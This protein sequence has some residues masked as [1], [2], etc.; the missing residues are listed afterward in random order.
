MNRKFRLLLILTLFYGVKLVGQKLDCQKIYIW[1]FK[2]DE[3][4][5]NDITKTITNEVEEIF[6]QINSCKILQRRKNA[7]LEKQKQNEIEVLNVEGM[8][9][10]LKSQLRTIEAEKV[11][12]GEV[13][14][15]FSF[16]CIVRISLESLSTKEI[17]KALKINIKAKEMIDPKDRYSILESEIR[18]FLDI[19]E[20]G[21]N[22]IDKNI[23][24]RI[25]TDDCNDLRSKASQMGF[26]LSSNCSY[27]VVE[28]EKDNGYYLIRVHSRGKLWD[29]YFSAYY[30]IINKSN[31]SL[32]KISR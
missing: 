17:L 8:S 29:E 13:E 6:S 10:G 19:K 9:S 1:D 23:L 32:I 26:M 14:L 15:D 11:L 21:N 7:R 30:E 2:T 20:T 31:Y 16:N 25:L 27:R 22:L 3:N 5:I 28:F 18:R 12:F 4:E 24:E